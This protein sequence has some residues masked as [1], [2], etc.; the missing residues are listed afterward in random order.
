M[1]LRRDMIKLKVPNRSIDLAFIDICG[2]YTGGIYSWIKLNKYKFTKNAF[3]SLTTIANSRSTSR[4]MEIGWM[5]KKGMLASPKYIEKLIPTRITKG[6]YPT[7]NTANYMADC[8]AA[9][10]HH[11]LCK[12][13][14]KNNNHFVHQ[15]LYR[16]PDNK[17]QNMAVTTIQ[18]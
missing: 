16:S 17:R 3:V 5:S 11:Q 13:P 15:I 6:V 8:W 12:K 14:T 18:L 2:E 9:M 10:F 7:N 4:H 1:D